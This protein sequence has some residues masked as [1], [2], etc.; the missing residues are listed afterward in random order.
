M[1]ITGSILHQSWTLVFSISRTPYSAPADARGFIQERNDDAP[2]TIQIKDQSHNT[3]EKQT[4][5]ISPWPVFDAMV[6]EIV[7]DLRQRAPQ[8][9]PLR[10][11][12][13]VEIEAPR[14]PSGL[15]GPRRRATT[16]E[17]A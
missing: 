5:A 15:I 13:E 16:T 2:W 8:R 3:I 1:L 14:R 17:A 9:A 7:D 12:K 4:K 6:A 11:V 10:M